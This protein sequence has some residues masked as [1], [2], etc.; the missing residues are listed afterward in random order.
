MK[1]TPTA[2]PEVLLLEPRAFSDE[3][4]FFM[5]TFQAERYRAAGIAAPFVQDNLSRSEQGVLRGLHFQH[6]YG[7]GKLVYVLEGE[8]FDVAVDVRRGSPTFG[9]WVG[10]YLDSTKK[11]QFWI[12]PGFA[13]GFCVTSPTALFAYKCTAL[14]SPGTERSLR[15]DDP[16]IGI[17]WPLQ[18]VSLSSKDRSAP[19]LRDLNQGHLPEYQ[20]LPHDRR[21]YSGSAET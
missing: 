21:V 12:P 1:I 6:P 20:Q 18:K 17:D 10:V 3:R 7:Q 13:H 19:C 4:G 16:V 9:N 14:Y 11:S 5:E 8:V 2:I 15:W